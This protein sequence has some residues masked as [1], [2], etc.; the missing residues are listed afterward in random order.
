MTSSAEP[1]WLSD[2]LALTL[3]GEVPVEHEGR[4][5]ISIRWHFGLRTASRASVSDLLVAVLFI[6]RRG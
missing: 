4:R 2:P 1:V 6:Q 5:A 3:Q